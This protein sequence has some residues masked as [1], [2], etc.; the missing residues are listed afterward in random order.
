MEEYAALPWGV[1][2]GLGQSGAQD[3]RTRQQER[4][5]LVDIYNSQAVNEYNPAEIY[6]RNL[7]NRQ[8]ELANKQQEYLMPTFKALG[9]EANTKMDTPGFYQ[10][11]IDAT[12]ATNNAMRAAKENERVASE[13]QLP[14]VG[15]LA[16]AQAEQ[17]S[18]VTQLEN[19]RS[20]VNAFDGSAEEAAAW[21]QAKAPKIYGWIGSVLKNK[22][23]EPA[24]RD[25]LYWIDEQ[26]KSEYLRDSAHI[27]AVDLASQKG[28]A[29]AETDIEFFKRDPA[30]F[31]KYRALMTSEAAPSILRL[32][33]Y[34]ASLRGESKPSVDDIFKAG[35]AMNQVPSSD[36]TT[37]KQLE[38]KDGK[39]KNV[40]VVQKRPG[41]QS[42]SGG[43]DKFTQD[44]LKGTAPVATVAPG[45]RNG[46]AT[47]QGHPVRVKD[48]KVYL[49]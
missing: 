23:I 15:A 9:I 35:A 26:L 41:P 5:K 7:T 47:F 1:R 48:G 43:E 12:Q 17:K 13:A 28:E 34:I 20:A 30:G 25:L 21:L 6:N 4:D 45:T 38:A 33:Y 8:Q 32:A 39:V 18:R 36:T 10:S 37:T 42:P 49:K 27:R 46:N 2:W 19:F 16:G 44:Q 14:H 40:E 24:R 3:Y 22:G 31:A 29:K 11:S